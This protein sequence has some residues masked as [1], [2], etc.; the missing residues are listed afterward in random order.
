MKVILLEKIRNLGELG[1]LVE[2]KAGYARNYL[3]PEGKAVFA[4]KANLAE[5]ESKRAELEKAAAGRLS[6]SEQRAKLLQGQ[7]MVITARATE[8]GKLFGS[9][10]VREIVEALAKA[11]FSVERREVDLPTGPIH[12]IGE[13][14]IQLLLHGDITAMIKINIEKA[15]D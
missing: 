7:A 12:S 9:V 13:Y 14:N 11:G 1:A 4:T 6:E 2:V 5:F 15:Q 8:E 10:G 3:I